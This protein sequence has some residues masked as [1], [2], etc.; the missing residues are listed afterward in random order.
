[1]RYFKITVNEEQMQ[2][3]HNAMLFYFEFLSG[4]M[5]LPAVVNDSIANIKTIKMAQAFM[6][7]LKSVIYPDLSPN[8]HYQLG[9][10]HSNDSKRKQEIGLENDNAWEI[11]RDL[12]NF[13]ASLKK[14][15]NYSRF[16]VRNFSGN[17]P[18]EIEEFDKWK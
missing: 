11:Y 1:M 9:S 17:L 5:N 2:V 15:S 10:H 6:S 14:D 16:V 12:A 8:S 4:K 13:V 3:V 18:I 7:E